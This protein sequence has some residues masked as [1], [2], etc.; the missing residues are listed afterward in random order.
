MTFEGLSYVL[1]NRHKT[2]NKEQIRKM[3]AQINDISSIK[4]Q[5]YL[6]I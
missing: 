6:I 1:S 3:P 4:S 5:V 2:K